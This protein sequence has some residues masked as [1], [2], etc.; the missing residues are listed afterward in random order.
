MSK[1]RKLDRSKRVKAANSLAISGREC[2][3]LFIDQ[4]VETLPRGR[5]T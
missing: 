3:F 2:V 5:P 1:Q 4:I